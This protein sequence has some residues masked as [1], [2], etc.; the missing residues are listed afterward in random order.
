MKMHK[1][2]DVDS[3]LTRKGFHKKEGGSHTMYIFYN[4]ES[5]KVTSIFT[6]MSRGNKDPGIENLKRM[7]K[8]LYFD[9]DKD[10]DDFIDC[11]YTKEMYFNNLKVKGKI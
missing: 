11:L 7:K 8:Q 1:A 4:E 10:F 9:E 2:R 6:L 5:S 3:A